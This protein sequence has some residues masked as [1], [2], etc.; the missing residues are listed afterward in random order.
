[1]HWP[2]KNRCWS[3]RQRPNT[4]IAPELRCKGRTR[5]AVG[6]QGRGQVEQESLLVSEAETNINCSW[7]QMQ[8]PSKNR[9]W[10]P[11]LRPNKNRCWSSKQSP[12]IHCSWSPRLQP[13]RNRCWSP[14]LRRTRIIAGLRGRDQIFIVPGLRGCAEQESLLVSEAET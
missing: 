10:S 12:N 4:L 8:R 1:M 11:R 2:N 14:R 9:C 13:N 7:F 6:L 5:I 3:L